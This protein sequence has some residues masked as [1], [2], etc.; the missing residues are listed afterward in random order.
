MLLLSL[1]DRYLS[2]KDYIE[3]ALRA[4]QGHGW[5]SFDRLA[6]LGWGGRVEYAC[7]DLGADFSALRS[8]LI[9]HLRRKAQPLAAVFHLAGSYQRAHVADYAPADL[10]AATRAKVWGA[11][12]LHRAAIAAGERPAFVHFGSVATVYAGTGLGGY[13][14]ANAFLAWFACWQ[15]DTAG[16]EARTIEWA[17]WSGIG[18]SQRDEARGMASWLAPLPLEQGLAVLRRLVAW[19]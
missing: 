5:L 10:A 14:G 12:H 2:C 7:I 17:S 13:A 9:G 18:I 11:V 19:S 16:L 15:H 8:A 3:E 4:A 6:E 1:L